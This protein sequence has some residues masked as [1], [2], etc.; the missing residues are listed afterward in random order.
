MRVLVLGLG[1]MGFRHAKNA[2]MLGHEVTAW[3]PLPVSVALPAGVSLAVGP[4]DAWATRPE[5]VVIAT[6]AHQHAD[7]LA[8][9]RHAGAS[10]L[11]EKPLA[12]SVYAL[13]RNHVFPAPGTTRAERAGYNLR[14]HTGVRV[15]RGIL[16]ERPTTATFV[17]RC[18]KSAWPGKSYDDMLLEG[19]HEIDLALWL[20][21]PA[22]VR[23]A[24]GHGDLWTLVLVHESGCVSTIVLDGR[25]EGYQRRC[26]I[27]SDAALVSWSWSSPDWAWEVR[28]GPDGP[29]VGHCPPE[30]T[31]LYELEDFLAA[32]DG[33]ESDELACTIHDAFRVLAA[34][35]DARRSAGIGL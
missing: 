27:R 16:P 7:G 4:H 8:Q 5:A 30:D 14:F 22:R 32:A 3:D 24:V 2:A 12:V 26:E 13:A 17:L 18:K 6:P 1:S 25:Y 28:G 31:Y 11:V 29:Q 23:A 34:C 10:V 33:E 21:G 9:A 19:S 20:L 15:L 35:D